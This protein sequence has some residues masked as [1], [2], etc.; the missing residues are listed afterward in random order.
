M[1]L[2]HGPSYLFRFH[3]FLCF[4]CYSLLNFM[5][6]LIFIYG[7]GWGFMFSLDLL[8]GSENPLY[9]VCLPSNTF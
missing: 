7:V 6:C 8:F 9:E 5:L 3:G 4:S 1:S 2:I